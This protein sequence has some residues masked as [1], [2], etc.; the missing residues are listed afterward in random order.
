MRTSAGIYIVSNTSVKL[1]YMYS[2]LE[3]HLFEPPKAAW[4]INMLQFFVDR[5]YKR[6]NNVIYKS[7]LIE[8]R[9]VYIKIKYTFD[10]MI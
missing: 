6:R 4:G 7:I 1:L 8:S 2:E 3:K 5:F 9:S 10:R